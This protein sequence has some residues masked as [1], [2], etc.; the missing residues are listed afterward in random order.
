ME[1]SRNVIFCTLFYLAMAGCT[2]PHPADREA[3]RFIGEYEISIPPLEKELNLASWNAEITGKPGDFQAREKAQNSLDRALADPARFQELVKIQGLYLKN[4]QHADPL[5]LRQVDLLYLQYLEKQLD[6]E[7]LEKMTALESSVAKTFNNFRAR[8]DGKELADSEVRKILKTSKDPIYRK[9]VW[10]ASK[11]VGAAVEAD[12]RELVKLRNQAARKLRFP[13]F[14]AMK[15][16]LSELKRDEVLKL[17]DELH[18]LTLEPFR[19]VKAEIDARLARDFG[20]SATELRPWHYQDPFFQDAPVLSTADFDALYAGV[21]I[22]K[23]CGEFY[24]GIGLPVDSVLAASDLHEKEGKN[25]HAFCTDIDRQGDVRVLANIVPSE[26]WM[27]TLLHEL[28][29]AVYSSKY[30]PAST[31]YLLREPA[32]ILCTEGIAMMFEKFSKSADWLLEMGVNVPDREKFNEAGARQRRY[33]LL[34]FAAWSQVMFRF[35]MEMYKNP[36]QDL[37]RLWW[38]LV[39]TYQLIHRPE[40]RDAPDYAAKIHVANYPAYYHNYLMGQLFASQ[41]H[42]TIAREVLGVEPDRALYNGRKE[43]GRFLEEKVFKPGRALN[44]QQLTKHA[45]GRELDARAFAAEVG[46]R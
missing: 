39:E 23:L 24:G 37:N 8:V 7:L 14:H 26:Y 41:V 35:E 3:S 5:L 31:P 42:E 22:P 40:N 32:H 18:R 17:F 2:A 46:A 20:I 25:P 29:H 10:E 43:V 27:A 28:G 12:L 19:E 45:T 15:L 6:P 1:N 34:I 4:P 36:D 38:D 11:A 33:Q 16:Y 13:D 21:D 44:W 30:M 9:K